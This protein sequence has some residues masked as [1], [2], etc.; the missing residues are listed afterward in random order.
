MYF[1]LLV[2]HLHIARAINVNP[3]SYNCFDDY[4]FIFSTSLIIII[5]I[6]LCFFFCR[7]R[8]V[9]YIADDTKVVWIGSPPIFPFK[10]RDFCT[11]VHIRK[12]KDG[13]IIVLNRSEAYYIIV[14]DLFQLNYC[15]L[16][17]HVIHLFILYYLFY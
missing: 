3:Y 1:C 7:F 10:P 14:L 16:P 12:L 15:I 13:T 5:I 11:I 4:I 2:N 9:E 17:F 6:F 8:D